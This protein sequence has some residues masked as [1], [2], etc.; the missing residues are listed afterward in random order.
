MEPLFP[1]SARPLVVIAVMCVTWGVVYVVFAR[2]YPL[3]KRGWK[4]VDFFWLGATAL[5]LIGTAGQVRQLVATAQINMLETFAETDLRGLQHAAD[6]LAADPGAVCRTWIRTQYSPPPEESAR[7]A[8]DFANV[9]EYFKAVSGA[10]KRVKAGDLVQSHHLPR[11]PVV[12][13]VD[14]RSILDSFR[15]DVERTNQTVTNLLQ[16]RS[17]AKRTDIETSLIILSPLLLAIALG[18]R[19]GKVN[20][21]LRLESQEQVKL[22]EGPPESTVQTSPRTT[23]PRTADNSETPNRP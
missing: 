8:R 3:R 21:E 11:Q 7:I 17:A 22:R 2:L 5:G 4:I 19:L 14:L 18:L 9:C 12:P 15:A 1:L 23:A 20:G 6:G 10:L 13:E 16:L